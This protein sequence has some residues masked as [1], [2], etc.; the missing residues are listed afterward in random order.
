[1][2]SESQVWAVSGGFMSDIEQFEREKRDF[3]TRMAADQALAAKAVDLITHADRY[4][5]TYQWTWL[6]LP[7]IQFPQD[8][9]ALQEIIWRTKPTVIV[10]TGIARGGSLVFFASMLQLLGRGKVVGVDIDI[11]AH[12]RAAIDNHPF[13]HRIEMI[14]GSSI[15]AA[16]VDQ[17]KAH[18]TREDRV[19]VVLDSNHTH[20]HVLAELEAFAPLVSVGQHLVVADTVVEMI[21][22]QTHRPRHWGPGN[23]PMT[24]LRAFMAANTDFVPDTESNDKLL[25]SSSFEGYLIRREKA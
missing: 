5:Y 25:L 17:V 12:N 11:R 4:N 14:E 10:E 8:I 3:A 6:G 16:T 15:A 18:I 13:R 2:L 23:N 21:P 1:V 24:A 22:E 19:M 7:I 9:V 20:D